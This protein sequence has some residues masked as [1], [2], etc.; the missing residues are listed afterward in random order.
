MTHI[1]SFTL[2][3]THCL[4]KYTLPSGVL[5][6]TSSRVN[7]FS[8]WAN[9]SSLYLLLVSQQNKDRVDLLF[10]VYPS[11]T[12]IICPQHYHSVFH[13]STYPTI[14]T[15]TAVQQLCLQT[16]QL[17]FNPCWNAQLDL[18]FFLS[19]F[20]YMLPIQ[21]TY[22]LYLFKHLQRPSDTCERDP[23]TGGSVEHI[24][25]TYTSEFC[26]HLLRWARKGELLAL[27][28]IS[29]FCITAWSNILSLRDLW[30]IILSAFLRENCHQ[31][32]FFRLHFLAFKDILWRHPSSTL[33]NHG[34]RWHEKKR[35]RGIA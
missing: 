15:F 35:P 6:G 17:Q 1:I 14:S 13:I 8:T 2:V 34:E 20:L 29:H 19:V 27:P 16:A 9:V 22:N 21:S 12:T 3:L 5:N 18:H 31:Y 11:F 4:L 23:Y 32:K 7:C 25:N 30:L 28:F 26:F 10:A 24:S 33:P